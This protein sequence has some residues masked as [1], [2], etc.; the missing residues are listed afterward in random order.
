MDAATANLQEK[1]RKDPFVAGWF[2]KLGEILLRLDPLIQ[3]SPLR[4][5]NLKF[6]AHFEQA[7]PEAKKLLALI[8]HEPLTEEQMQQLSAV[9]QWLNFCHEIYEALVADPA[10]MAQQPDFLFLETALQEEMRN[11]DVDHFVNFV[12]NQLMP[13]SPLSYAKCYAILCQTIGPNTKC[14]EGFIREIAGELTEKVGRAVNY[15]FLMSHYPHQMA[16][17]LHKNAITYYYQHYWYD[18]GQDPEKLKSKINWILPQLQ[19]GEEKRTR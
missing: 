1:T 12:W 18:R 13:G 9:Y 16:A 15:E 7:L 14:A 19:K 5:T 10:T 17:Y 6:A 3:A 2:S 4:I 11:R 8:E